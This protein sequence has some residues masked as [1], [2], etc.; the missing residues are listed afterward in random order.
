LDGSAAQR[1]HGQPG[2]A[3]PPAGGQLVGGDGRQLGSDGPDLFLHGL[4][5]RVQFP[6]ATQL[7][8]EPARSVPGLDLG[9]HGHRGHLPRVHE[10][11]DHPQKLEFLFNGSYSYYESFTKKDW[12]TDTL[13]PFLGPSVSGTPI[14]LGI[15]QKNY[16]AQ[17]VGVTLKYKFE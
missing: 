4:C 14:F 7:R 6:E 13:T 3:G 1:Q 10:G 15:D 2:A 11:N 16:W 8:P 12:Q 17:I 5:A 9:Q